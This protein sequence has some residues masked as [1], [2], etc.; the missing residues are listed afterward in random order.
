[1]PRS[2]SAVAAFIFSTGTP[3]IA[4]TVSA[5]SDSAT[6]IASS[7]C[8]SFHFFSSSP[9]SADATRIASRYCAAASKSPRATASSLRPRRSSIAA[10]LSVSDFG[11]ALAPILILAPVSSMASMAL[12][13]SWRAGR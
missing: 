3:L 6:S 8:V 13:G 1:M 5:T 9:N 7:A 11:L 2:F 12:S 10:C 4:A